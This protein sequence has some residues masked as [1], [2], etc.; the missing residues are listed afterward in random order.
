[1]AL[2]GWI[3]S[4]GT[5]SLVKFLSGRWEA[6][7]FETGAGATFAAQNGVELVG[8]DREHDEI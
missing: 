7:G 6:F 8:Q 2:A 4:A 5:G 3:L 1:M